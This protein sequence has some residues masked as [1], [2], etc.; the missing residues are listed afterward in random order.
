MNQKIKP[1]PPIKVKI[2]WWNQTK[3]WFLVIGSFMLWIIL[4]ISGL[5]ILVYYVFSANT[6]GFFDQETLKYAVFLVIGAYFCL[7]LDKNKISEA[8]NVKKDLPFITIEQI[9]KKSQKRHKK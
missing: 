9:D 8:L 6:K 2:N 1:L 3:L 5:N 7:I 4:L